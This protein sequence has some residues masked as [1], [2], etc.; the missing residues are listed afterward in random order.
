MPAIPPTGEVPRFFTVEEANAL[1]P[2]LELEFGR[3]A[4]ARSELDP[5]VASLTGPV[6]M[7]ILKYGAAAPAGHEAEATRMRELVG[8]ITSAVLRVSGLG[9][10]VKDLDQGLVDFYSMSSGEPVFL[11]WQFGEPEVAHWHAL[12]DGFAGRSPLSRPG[13]GS[14]YPN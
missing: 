4:R 11:C 13:R 1:V 9:C 14:E 7:A 5:L 6:A 10:L 8:E 12:N 2:A 3:V